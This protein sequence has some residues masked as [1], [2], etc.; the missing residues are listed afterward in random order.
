MSIL[1]KQ[2]KENFPFEWV[3][4]ETYPLSKGSYIV[5]K[6]R[7]K[8]NIINEMIKMFDYLFNEIEKEI[9]IYNEYWGDFCLDVWDVRSDN[10]NYDEASLSK[11]TK[12]Y[13][14]MLKASGIENDFIGSCKCKDWKS[15]LNI[16]LNCIVKHIAPYSPVLY[17]PVSNFFFY[18]HYTGEIG[19]YYK[20]K[21]EVLEKIINKW[22]HYIID[23]NQHIYN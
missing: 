4:L 20:I 9:N 17:S 10:Y 19:L 18:F 21:N 22:N 1:E 11:E 3:N 6:I 5:F 14:N 13:M 23:E 7:N 2:E 8:N 16:I 12:E 15:F